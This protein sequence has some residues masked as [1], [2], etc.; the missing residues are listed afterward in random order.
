MP[1]ISAIIQYIL[2]SIAIT[3]ESSK[4]QVLKW[5][6]FFSLIHLF[7]SVVIFLD[8]SQDNNY[9]WGDF[10][11]RSIVPVLIANVVKWSVWGVGFKFSFPS[12][13]APTIT[14]L[15]NV[16]HT[17]DLSKYTISVP[18]YAMI[19]FDNLNKEL[20]LLKVYWMNVQTQHKKL[21]QKVNRI[22]NTKFNKALR[23]LETNLNNGLSRV[24]YEVDKHHVFLNSLKQQDNVPAQDIQILTNNLVT[25]GELNRD[26]ETLSVFFNAAKQFFYVLP[27]LGNQSLSQPIKDIRQLVDRLQ[28][29]LLDFQKH[30]ILSTEKTKKQPWVLEEIPQAI[31][32][33]KQAVK[34]GFTQVEVSALSYT[35]GIQ[36]TQLE[37]LDGR[38][39][40]LFLDVDALAKRVGVDVTVEESTPPSLKRNRNKVYR[41]ET[42][43]K[44]LW[45]EYIVEE[46]E[47]FWKIYTRLVQDSKRMR[48]S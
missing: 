48:Q 28:Q 40:L 44:E 10:F 42:Q 16:V 5:T 24:D 43:A 14:E 21:W 35:A 30:Q 1:F 9:F 25:L 15:L 41:V 34:L 17:P 13:P 12:S 11:Y 26:F 7:V 27:N 29:I 4:K 47:K 6:L 32:H 23:V 3:T 18:E 46:E 2:L 38:L 36:R 45:Q 19:D 33:L 8:E 31:V 37:A 22:S 20:A 39:T